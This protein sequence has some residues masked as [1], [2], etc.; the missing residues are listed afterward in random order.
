MATR[1]DGRTP[2]EL[3]PIEVTTSVSKNAFG[4]CLVKFGDTHVLCAATIEESVP[5]WR[6]NKGLGWVTAEYSMLPTAGSG[7]TR[8][9]RQGAKGRTLEIERLIGRSLRS[10]V[11]MSGLG[12]EVTVTI[13][14]DVLQADGGTRTAAITGGY[15][16]LIEALRRWKVAGKI[17]AIPVHGQVGAI[18]V[19]LVD[20]DV[21]LDMD[22]SEDVRAEVDMNV[23]MDDT[24]RFIE[25]QGT[26]EQIPFDRE[27]LNAMLDLATSGI[28]RL[29][30]IQRAALAE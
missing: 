30:E 5:P 9:E 13:D 14:C 22:Y 16:A 26:G 8:R 27:R 20:G 10:V 18:S 15:I 29:I 12:G 17:Q 21:V 7:R 24:G 23:V 4:S 28:D 3:R 6:R 11:D 1:R 19:G 25:V 2:E